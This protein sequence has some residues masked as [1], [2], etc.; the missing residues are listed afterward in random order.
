MPVTSP[1]G[2][3]LSGTAGFTVCAEEGVVC[4]VL[5]KKV[6]ELALL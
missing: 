6:E 1:E 4:T 5:G 3:R 2:H